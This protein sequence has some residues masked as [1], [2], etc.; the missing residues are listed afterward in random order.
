MLTGPKACEV[1]A[2]VEKND[3]KWMNA[4]NLITATHAVANALND[5]E[6]PVRVQAALALTEMVTSHD[7]G[8]SIQIFSLLINLMLGQWKTRSEPT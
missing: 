2:T 6:I 7:S 1:I 8:K 3:M 4:Q 5:P